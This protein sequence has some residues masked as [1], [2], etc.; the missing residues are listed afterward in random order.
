MNSD[1]GTKNAMMDSEQ[2]FKNVMGSLAMSSQASNHPN[3]TDTPDN[4]SSLDESLPR[5]LKHGRVNSQTSY[6][7]DQSGTL[8]LPGTTQIIEEENES[9]VS[10]LNHGVGSN[11]LS[12]AAGGGTYGSPRTSYETDGGGAAAGS[13]KV[14][15]A[16]RKVS[17]LA[18][19]RAQIF[20]I[21]DAMKS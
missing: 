8:D 6:K 7:H 3:K 20:S 14:S 1:K 2:M 4:Q 19:Q 12:S 21:E 18:Q 17:E 5:Q 16:D 11:R 13:N 15:E 10:H 9:D